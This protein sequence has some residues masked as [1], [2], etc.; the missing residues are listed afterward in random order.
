L[1]IQRLY[2]FTMPDWT[3]KI[4]PKYQ[5]QL[6]DVSAFSFRMITYTAE[7]KRLKGGPLVK[8]LIKNINSKVDQ[9]L[10]ARRKFFMFSAH[11]TVGWVN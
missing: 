2:N 5:Q 7:M 11:D 4:Y 10:D 3:N 6:D 8:E 1:F 9:S